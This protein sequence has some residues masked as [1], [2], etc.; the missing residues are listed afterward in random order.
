MYTIDK[1]LEFC[2]GHRVWTQT[3]DG[4]FSSD[5][6]CACRHLH[7]HEAKVQI[8]LTATRLNPQGMVTD[9]RHLEWAKLWV[10]KYVDHKF[11][12]HRE[13]P[14]LTSIVPL[15]SQW[16]R[17]NVT[18]GGDTDSP[19][20]LTA[21]YLVVKDTDA[22]EPEYVDELRDG[23]LILD[24]VPTSENLARWMFQL[25]RHYMSPLDVQI[26]QVDWWETPRSRSSYRSE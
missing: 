19:S 26:T 9:F 24:F 25:V 8:F 5:L 18:P 11:L 6:Q 12:V 14:A 7:G 15:L 13:D 22:P 4:R 2:Y 1:T 3:L 23:I 16:V 17:L 21:G 20:K 10:N